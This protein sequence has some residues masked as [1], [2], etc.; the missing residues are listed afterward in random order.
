MVNYFAPLWI[1]YFIII[2]SFTIHFKFIYGLNS[3]IIRC[4]KTHQLTKAM[5]VF[6]FITEK[7]IIVFYQISL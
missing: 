7:K 3:L 2:L 4:Q 1:K 5:E 6:I